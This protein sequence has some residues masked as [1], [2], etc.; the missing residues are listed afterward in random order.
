M[1]VAYGF[2]LPTLCG[3][4][5][6]LVSKSCCVFDWAWFMTCFTMRSMRVKG[7]IFQRSSDRQTHCA[8]SIGTD[9]LQSLRIRSTGQYVH[10]LLKNEAW[11]TK[12]RHM[13]S[14]VLRSA[15]TRLRWRA[16][17]ASRARR[18]SALSA[19]SPSPLMRTGVKKEGPWRACQNESVMGSLSTFQDLPRHCIRFS[20]MHSEFSFYIL[21]V[22]GWRR[23]RVTLLLVSAGVRDRLKPFAT[24]CNCP[25]TT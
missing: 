15:S 5:G 10:F 24:V 18:S 17:T 2:G 22:W 19:P 9:I 7:T 23:V 21:G 13:T 14:A 11:R 3:I 4:D 20:R 1:V 6:R 25:R 12:Q 16:T 8:D